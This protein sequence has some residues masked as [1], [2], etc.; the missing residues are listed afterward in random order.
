MSIN[1]NTVA[2]E[3]GMRRDNSRGGEVQYF[4]P[5][6]DQDTADITVTNGDKFFCFPSSEG[7]H[8]PVTLVMHAENID[9]TAAVQ[10][11]KEHFPDEFG[12]A[13]QETIKRR[14]AARQVLEHVTQESH[15]HLTERKQQLAADIKENRNLTDDD[16]EKYMIGFMHQEIVN[17]TINK[18]DKQALIDSG[19]FGENDGEI[20]S[21]LANRI[22]LPYMNAG[23]TTFMA[24]R[25]TEESYSQD[26][27][28]KK[29]YNTDYNHHSLFKFAGNGTETAIITEGFTDAISADKAGFDTYSPATVQFRSDD[30]QKVVESVD[31]Y[32]N[33][34]I[35]NDG[36]EAGQEGAMKTADILTKEGNEPTIV[37]LDEGMDL[38]DWTTENGYDLGDLLESG[39]YYM[40]ELV[41]LTKNGDRK[42]RSDAKQ[43]IFELVQS[44]NEMQRNEL[45]QDMPGSLER[46]Q[47]EY[48]SVT[49]DSGTEQS[50]SGV[51]DDVTPEQGKGKD[52][53]LPDEH[54]PGDKYFSES[55]AFRSNKLAEDIEDDYHFIYSML[56]EKLYVYQDGVYEDAERLV[57][58]QAN[59]RLGD[60]FKKARVNDTMEAIETRPGVAKTQK[61][62]QP[63]THLVNFN[64]GLFNLQEGE[65]ESHDP[66]YTFTQQI[67]HD[68][69][70]TADDS[71]IKD[72]VEEI[73]A[74][75]EDAETIYEMTGYTMNTAMPIAKAFMMVG[76]G[77]NG[78]TVFL[79]LL[80]T[81]IGQEHVKDETLQQL[82]N[83]RFATRHLY[84]KLMVVCDDL[85]S[86]E[87][88]EGGTLKSLTGGSSVRAEIKGGDSFE[89]DNYALPVMAANEV[90][91]S[92]DQ[93]DGFFRRWEIIDFP[94]RFVQNPDSNKPHE[95][96]AT[97]KMKLNRKLHD[98]EQLSGFVTQAVLAFKKVWDKGEFTH[99][100]Q[101]Q[102]TRTKWNSYA[103]PTL[104]FLN[105]YVE[106]GISKSE[107]S[108]RS[109][110]N[111]Q[112]HQN[113]NRFDYDFIAKDE[114]HKMI[115]LFNQSRSN[116]PPTKNKLTRRINNDTELYASSTRSN[117][118]N[119]K[120]G[121]VSIYGN[122]RYNEQFQKKIDEANTVQE[123]KASLGISNAEG[124]I[125]HTIKDKIESGDSSETLEEAMERV[126]KA[127]QDEEGIADMN[128][129]V[130]D[131]QMDEGKAEEIIT[132]KLDDGE[133]YE[134][135]PGKVAELK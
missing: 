69:D 122:I 63:P 119:F 85:P 8:S 75:K 17:E 59:Q 18:F 28:Y 12:D 43:S 13:D 74:T 99:S 101:P 118:S 37:Q 56:E 64:N 66:K 19:I 115:E 97:P 31:N 30:I 121:M 100:Q 81:A 129:L 77:Q 55:G 128:T 34:Y 76:Q 90:P 127:A 15:D 41:D 79:N 117:Q 105:T 53:G 110:D 104:E 91:K 133:W 124:E 125:P 131:S 32:S 123:F 62:M 96:Q 84:R 130:E 26:Q 24:G 40:D 50:T 116:R 36:D 3:L 93:S 73:T 88:A 54:D 39:Q 68:F 21:H 113:Y 111:I 94:Y 11:L 65:L 134:P 106:R 92:Q 2:D 112:D 67:P 82:E 42:E 114:L 10:W 9:K 46:V 58:E 83:G 103:D 4:C 38:D 33:V 71:D 23:R 48:E 51:S 86:E 47:K 52:T 7:G 89:F 57:K 5:Q 6:H 20:Y 14:D 109:R 44:W 78:K 108:E 22:T 25:A 80:R 1:L 95:K 70:R 45:F 135:R 98:E 120:D 126:M 27:K 49:G 16:L 35:I 87:L 61:Q 72:F 132:R 29:A 107:A 102:E 60:Y